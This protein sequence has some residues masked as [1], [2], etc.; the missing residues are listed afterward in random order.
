MQHDEQLSSLRAMAVSKAQFRIRQLFDESRIELKTELR[1]QK[2][3]EMGKEKIEQILK[4][5]ED[6][7]AH[8][9]KENANLEEAI[10]NL[11]VWIESVKDHKNKCEQ[12]ASRENEEQ[13][14]DLLAI[15]ADT[16]SAQ[17]LSLSSEVNTIDDC[18]YFLDRALVKGNI[19][20]DVFLKEVRKLSKRQ[21]MAKVSIVCVCVACLKLVHCI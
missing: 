7:K 20:L 3:L 19:S 5:G 12:E 1:D 10:Q 14:I 2:L 21:F 4:D 13:K 11:E 16:H 6:R 15:P 18:I 17:M 9:V 8:F